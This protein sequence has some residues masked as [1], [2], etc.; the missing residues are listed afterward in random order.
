MSLMQ[1]GVFMIHAQTPSVGGVLTL[2][3]SGSPAT[4]R[5]SR[6]ACLPIKIYSNYAYTR[7]CNVVARL[8]RFRCVSA[9]R[10][11]NHDK[12][13]YARYLRLCNSFHGPATNPPDMPIRP[14]S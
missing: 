11:T 8:G 1:Q 5:R 14:Q 4:N 2:H 6:R 7:L 10:G 13:K 3:V 9:S 12:A